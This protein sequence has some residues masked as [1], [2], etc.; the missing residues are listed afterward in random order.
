MAGST[1]GRSGLLSAFVE[2]HAV[3]QMVVVSISFAVCI[4]LMSAVAGSDGML[5]VNSGLAITLRFEFHN[6]VLKRTLYP[7][8][9]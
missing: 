6:D 7:R 4:D 2:E 3:S 9:S 8:A 1:N 5:G